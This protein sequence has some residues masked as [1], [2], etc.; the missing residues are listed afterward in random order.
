MVQRS[1]DAKRYLV[2]QFGGT[3][4]TFSSGG[5]AD[6]PESVVIASRRLY[7]S[8]MYAPGYR[9]RRRSWNRNLAK[10]RDKCKERSKGTAATG[11]R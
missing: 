2:R 3:K 8:A 10:G 5:W 1:N 9:E 7:F 11:R 6:Y 4:S